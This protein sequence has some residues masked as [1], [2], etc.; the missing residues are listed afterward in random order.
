MADWKADVEVDEAIVRALVGTQFPDVSL[1]GLALLAEGWDNAVWVTG[2]G[3]AFRFPRREVAI[4]GVARE[5]AVL[6][7]LA[8][9]LPLPIPVPELVGHPADR[10]PWP[11]FGARLLAGAELATLDMTG[12]R[13]GFARTLASFLRALHDPA[14]AADLGVGLPID[15]MG[16]ADMTIRAARVRRRLPELVAAGLWSRAGIVDDLLDEA[17]ALPPAEGGVLVHGDLHVRHVLVDA[18]GVPSGVIDWGD[19]C[20]GD[21]SIDLALYWSQFDAAARAAF[22][23][24]YGQAKLTAAR[25]LR[26]RVL[27]LSLDIDLALYAHETGNEA[28]LR[29]TLGGLTRTVDDSP[30]S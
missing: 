25:L 23:D 16:R 14:N 13:E 30:A 5:I 19:V 11:F 27:A 28:L 9:R 12:R 2:E 8:P 21:P 24:A 29:T 18:E 4:A 7:A 3:T 15:P 1:D 10:Y 20:V 6:P 17:L 26:A 22:Q